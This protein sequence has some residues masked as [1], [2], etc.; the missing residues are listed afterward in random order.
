MNAV[1]GLVESYLRLNGY[2]TATEFQVQ[3][4]L[5]G[6]VGRYDTATDLD[7]LAVRLPPAAE[8]LLR[9][10]RKPGEWRCEI[11][12]ARDPV[13]GAD[14][15]MPDILI[16]EV[17]EGAAALNVTLGHI[18]EFVAHHMHAYREIWRSAQFG[19]PT[20]ALLK[21]AEKLDLRLVPASTSEP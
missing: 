1:V 12:V 20:L 7:I 2:F 11:A 17:K 5:A 16:G 21:L 4:P 15:Q 6:Q 13:L 3:Q 14:L 18:L 19:D 8:T 10:P 9:H